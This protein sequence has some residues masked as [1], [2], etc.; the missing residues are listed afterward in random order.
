M[1]L[2]QRVINIE[3]SDV[4]AESIGF[5]IKDPAIMFDI[6]CT[7]LYDNP[8]KIVVQE[9]MCNARDS[10]REH[11]NID[12][13]I[14]VVLPTLFS[15]VL[16]IKDK[17]VGISPSRMSEVFVFL[18]ESTKNDSD[19]Q[20]G[21]FGVGAKTGWAYTDSFTVRTI[22]N[23][24]EYLYLAYI[25]TGNIGYIDLIEKS[26]TNEHNGTTI[27]INI[28]REDFELTEKYV[29]RTGFFW[30]VK[31]IIK[32]VQYYKD[33]VKNSSNIVNIYDDKNEILCTIK[34][35]VYD[36]LE[37]D[38]GNVVVVLD[39]IIYK[40]VNF[41]IKTDIDIIP[42]YFGAVY[43]HFKTSELKPTINRELR[44]TPD[45]INVMNTRIQEIM[46]YASMEFSDGIKSLETLKEFIE[47]CDSYN[48][49]KLDIF[50]NYKFKFKNIPIVFSK[51]RGMFCIDFRETCFNV[52]NY[53]YRKRENMLKVGERDY[54]LLDI[55]SIKKGTVV[56]NNKYTKNL[57]KDII[58]KYINDN[59]DPKSNYT[60]IDIEI[61]NYRE[62]STKDDN[63][64]YE[65]T[66]SFIL[67]EI[68]SV[69]D[70]LELYRKPK[71]KYTLQEKDDIQVYYYRGSNKIYATLKELLDNYKYL[72]STDQDHRFTANSIFSEYNN[73]YGNTFINFH[74]NKNIKTKKQ[75]IIKDFIISDQVAFNI[76]HNEIIKDIPRLM[77]YHT[78]HYNSLLGLPVD[79]FKFI[80]KSL[81]SLKDKKFYKLLKEIND[82]NNKISIDKIRKMKDSISLY[83]RVKREL[84]S[85]N[86]EHNVELL[87]AS[88]FFNRK[89]TKLKKDIDLF[90]KKYPL[91]KAAKYSNSMDL[92]PEDFVEYINDV[93]CSK[94]ITKEKTNEC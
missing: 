77:Y 89:K 65:E 37:E 63:K 57:N 31:P 6:L 68:I 1:K 36:Y 25:G 41:Y 67:K 16:K 81:S 69:T 70:L 38:K 71:D 50:K 78:F 19:M 21:G 42:R 75:E 76:I 92:N 88:N 61:I 45:S 84:I 30:D 83:K 59:L 28:N 13:P 47:Y 80:N 24:I 64:E 11:G 23:N 73:L 5:G 40:S 60:H 29:L 79:N 20:T 58:K 27:E 72:V 46:K 35:R 10:H 91:I 62:L 14:E 34:D 53:V 26:E 7:K 3:K 55:K 54:R 32:N 86:D 33:Y 43:V 74:Y 9:Y 90:Y 39:G 44:S 15:P 56:F 22:Y 49:Q 93:Y 4:G 18:G 87:L 8:L 2:D 94:K 12:E 66:F 17:G 51:D 48:K 85:D 52:S 82:I